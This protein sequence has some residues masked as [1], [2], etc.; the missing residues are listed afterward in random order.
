M[1]VLRN[2]IVLFC[3]N[4]SSLIVDWYLIRNM[5]M[6]TNF[7]D[8]MIGLQRNYFGYFPYPITI[9][10]NAKQSQRISF[11]IAYLQFFWHG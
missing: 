5:I 9:L 10:T 8:N 7:T 4:E 1:I 2:R 11:R 6:F 3:I